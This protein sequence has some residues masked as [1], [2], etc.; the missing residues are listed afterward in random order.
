MTSR[1]QL[2]RL[3]CQI[4][5]RGFKSQVKRRGFLQSDSTQTVCHRLKQWSILDSSLS[6]MNGPGHDGVFSIRLPNT[7]R[8]GGLPRIGLQ[9]MTRMPQSGQIDLVETELGLDRRV[10][11]LGPCVGSANTWTEVTVQ[12]GKTDLL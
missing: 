3:N 10:L 5:A 12:P 1:P 6:Q 4:L 11:T 8:S 2:K 9:P 7:E